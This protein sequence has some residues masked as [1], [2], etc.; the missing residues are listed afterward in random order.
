VGADVVLGDVGHPFEVEHSG[1]VDRFEHLL[2]L[3]VTEVRHGGSFLS[4]FDSQSIMANMDTTGIEQYISRLDIEIRNEPDISHQIDLVAAVQRATARLLADNKRRIAYEAKV[5]R[6]RSVII[7][8]R[9]GATEQTVNR[10]I[11]EWCERYRLPTPRLGIS[12]GDT[13]LVT[14]PD[15]TGGEATL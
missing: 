4:W 8:E 11:R 9:M 14:D 13:I 3:L 10:Y 6:V 7:A 1:G 5:K 2:D 15:R 12:E